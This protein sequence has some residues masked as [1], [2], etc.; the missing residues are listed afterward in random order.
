MDSCTPV[1]PQIS[2][3]PCDVNTRRSVVVWIYIEVELCISISVGPQQFTRKCICSN[4]HGITF[5]YSAFLKTTLGYTEVQIPVFQQPL[6]FRD[7]LQVLQGL[8]RC[9]VYTGQP[10]TRTAACMRLQDHQCVKP[11]YTKCTLQVL[12]DSLTGL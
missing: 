9:Y 6:N 4:T 3:Y 1:L 8:W 10:N 7:V 11:I 5:T 12:Y 2:K